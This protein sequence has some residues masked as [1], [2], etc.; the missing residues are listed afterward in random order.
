MSERARNVA[1]S[2]ARLP[3]PRPSAEPS[4][5]PAVPSTGVVAEAVDYLRSGV[6]V[7]LTGLRGTGRSH[8]V[9]HVI[10]ELAEAGHT[11]VQINGVAALRDRPLTALAVA[12]VSVPGVGGAAA[13]AGAAVALG[14]MVAKR[15]SVLVIDDADDLDMVSAGAVVAARGRHAF[16]TMVV[17]RRA[18]APSAAVRTLTSHFQPGVLL[19]VAPLGFGPLH[20]LLS[21]LLPGTVDP[22][23]FARIATKTGGVPALVRALVDTARRSG[24]L[25]RRGG[26]WRATGPLWDDALAAAVE[27]LVGD[28]T[29]EELDALARV[30]MV[31]AAPM[32]EIAGLIALEQFD[33]L[34]RSGLLQVVGSDGG[35]VVGVFPPLVAEY[36]RNTGSYASRLAADEFAARH[37]SGELLGIGSAP[38]LSGPGTAVVSRHISE[39]WELELGLL[40][41][42][43]RDDPV[44]D[45]TLPLLRA[46]D[47]T[48]SPRTTIDPVVT[49]VLAAGPSPTARAWSALYQGIALGDD[50][51][52][53]L[54][55]CAGTDDA[56]RTLAATA[57]HLRTLRHGVDPQEPVRPSTALLAVAEAERLLVAGRVLDAIEVLERTGHDEPLLGLDADLFRGLAWVM[58]GQTERGLE[59]AMDHFAA[60]QDSLDPA[61]LQS[62]AYVAV[63]GL[64]LNGDFD[65]LQKLF[66]AVM[67]G[68]TTPLLS[69]HFR[70]SLQIWAA[71][72]ASWRGDRAFAQ[73]IAQQ[74]EVFHA[75]RGPLPGMVP[76]LL[77]TLVGGRQDGGEEVWTEV[78]RMLDRGELAAAIFLAIPAAEMDPDTARIDRLVQACDGVQGPVLTALV[79]YVAAVGAG[80]PDQLAEAATALETAG[81]RLHAMRA[82]ITR[83]MALRDR[84]DRAGAADA[85]DLIWTA[86]AARGPVPRGL[87]A[88][89]V[90]TLELSPREI[91]SAKLLGRGMDLQQISALVEIS[92]RTVENHVF[93]LYKK[94]GVEGRDRLAR[95]ASTW[96]GA[97]ED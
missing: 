74:A 55:I 37:G 54:T 30:A 67:T 69:R 71:L 86:A 81:C 58:S 4:V 20:Q 78:G 96:L 22:A 72:A 18:G 6:H 32:A 65:Q 47:V 31:G 33:V 53:D 17:S 89:L 48:A 1:T 56:D 90:A 51:A 82:G 70:A 38:V 49:E 2:A 9:R 94:V 60:A 19:T 62:H 83:A 42:R 80:D 85:V 93:A 8:V 23:T 59:F 52:A 87:F 36:L 12:G 5:I 3:A 73:P 26:M 39:H 11:V 28:L 21:T 91:E 24:K 45:D 13:I 43:W 25:T 34:D 16:T 84:G 79:Q 46:L 27:P 63:L 61:G 50:E 41:R 10:A 66:D 76:S 75:D 97:G 14:G 15:G 68:T 88:R 44:G 29:P 77:C 64:V 95:A 35:P 57:L 7:N 92:P 40:H